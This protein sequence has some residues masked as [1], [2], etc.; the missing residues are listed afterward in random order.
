[1]NLVNPVNRVLVEFTEEVTRV[2]SCTTST[3]G[4][5]PGVTTLTHLGDNVHQV[6]FDATLEVGDGQNLRVSGE[7]SESAAPACYTYF[8]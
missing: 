7:H 3:G 4:S 1:M 5:P 8:L 2:G 6:Q